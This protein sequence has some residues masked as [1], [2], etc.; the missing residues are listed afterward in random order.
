MSRSNLPKHGRI[1]IRILL[2]APPG[3]EANLVVSMLVIQ[4]GDNLNCHI[5]YCIK[6]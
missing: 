3:K 1:M 2:A 4:L 6:S 5:R